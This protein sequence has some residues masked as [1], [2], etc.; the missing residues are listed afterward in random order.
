MKN[1]TRTTYIKERD[2]K[3]KE[4]QYQHKQHENK[5]PNSYSQSTLFTS[6]LTQPNPYHRRL[7]PDPEPD[8]EFASSRNTLVHYSIIHFFYIPVH[9]ICNGV[10]RNRLLCPYFLSLLSIYMSSKTHGPLSS[11]LRD[12]R[13]VMMRI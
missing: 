1:T 10:V 2:N 11:L 4:Q 6:K 13:F 8:P 3:E 9:E 12:E 5:I 7:K